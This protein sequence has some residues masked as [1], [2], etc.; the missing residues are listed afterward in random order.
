MNETELKMLDI[1]KQLRD[2]HGVFSVKSEF[3]AEGSRTEDLVRLN[4]IVYRADMKNCIKIGGCEAVR[5][6]D[7][8]LLLGAS[9][10]MA[11]M[12]ETPFAMSKFKSAASKFYGANIKNIEWIINAETKTCLNNFDDI[13]N[14]GAGFLNTITVG[15][16]DLSGSYG[17]PRSEINNDFMFEKTKEFAIKARNKGLIVDF[18]GSITEKAIPFI[19][20]MYPYIDKFETRKIIFTAEKDEN[21]IRKGII[22][23]TK[24]ETLYLINKCNFYGSKAIEDKERLEMMENRL[25]DADICI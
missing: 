25:K 18:G 8:C 1:L 16:D 22:L 3:E 2:E 24:F 21:K 12:I 13:L 17:L 6:L 23:A 4:E 11:P 5:D 20:R 19:C 7:Q 14:S 9:A 10:I 15:R